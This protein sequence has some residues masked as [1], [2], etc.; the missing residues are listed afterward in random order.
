MEVTGKR[1]KCAVIW[2]VEER[3]EVVRGSRAVLEEGTRIPMRIL[4]GEDIVVRAEEG[5]MA[6]SL[7]DSVEYVSG[8]RGGVV[9]SRTG[10]FGD[11]RV[12]YWR[13]FR[14]VDSVALGVS[15][16]RCRYSEWR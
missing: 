4:W 10:R 7:I 1:E 15:E 3:R 14:S 6:D 13:C 5:F 8:I 11:V 9:S 16:S 12:V 2:G